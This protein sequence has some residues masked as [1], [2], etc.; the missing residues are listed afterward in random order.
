MTRARL[1]WAERVAL[2]E[3]TV[4]LDGEPARL[5]GYGLEFPVISTASGKRAEWSWHAAKH[6]IQHCG[7]RF[8]L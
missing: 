5:S 4:T 6:I 2:T 8:E 3:A 1:T 7:G